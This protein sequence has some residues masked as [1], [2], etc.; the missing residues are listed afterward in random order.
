M[1][2][3]YGVVETTKITEICYDFYN[4]TT[5]IENGWVVAKGD[6]VT[7]ERNV[8]T[9]GIPATTDKVYLV[10][11]PAWS[12]SSDPDKQGEENFINV[13]Q[14]PFRGYGL[15]AT[16]KFGVTD[17]TITDGDTLVVGDFIGVDGTTMKL[18]KLDTEPTGVGFYGK[19]VEIEDTGIY[20]CLNVSTVTSPVGNPPTGGGVIVPQ[21]RKIVIEVVMNENV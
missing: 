13:K 21:G 17:Y 18:T 10:A 16:N 1:A 20:P 19:V 14:K 9:A 7:G 12:Y 11:N 5:N 4:S 6:L 15:A 8:Y 3:R 2:N